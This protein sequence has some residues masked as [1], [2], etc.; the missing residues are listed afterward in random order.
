LLGGVAVLT[1][2]DAGIILLVLAAYVLVRHRARAGWFGL[3][4]ALPLGVLAWYQADAFGAPW[5][6]PSTY[7]AGT[8]NGSTRGGYSIPGPRDILEVLF[9]SRGLALGAP[10]ALVALVA[11][12]WLVKRGSGPARRHAVVALA[13]TIPYVVLCAGWSGFALLEDPGPRYVIPILPFL[14]VPIAVLWDELWR[15]AVVAAAWGALVSVPA[16]FTYILV[17]SGQHL[18]PDLLRR[19]I[20]GKFAPTV[21]SMALGRLGIVVYVASV[22]VAVGAFARR[23]RVPVPSIR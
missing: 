10:V 19:M 22:V 2:Y 16:A 21:W 5:R 7:F 11:A 17:G 14:A 18:V 3:G 8:I 13:V 23:A 20:D 12:V 1:E 15:P 6:T 4:A 9:G